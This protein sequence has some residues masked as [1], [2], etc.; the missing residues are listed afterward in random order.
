MAVLAA[1]S[2]PLLLLIRRLAALQSDL[3]GRLMPPHKMTLLIGLFFL[4][5]Q[6]DR[7]WGR[8]LADWVVDNSWTALSCCVVVVGLSVFAPYSRASRNY[9]VDKCAAVTL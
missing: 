9:V 1:A 2:L 6:N 4:C 7:F 5:C 3:T 8:F